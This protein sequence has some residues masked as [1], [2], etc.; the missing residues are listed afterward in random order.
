MPLI[1]ISGPAGEPVTSAEIKAS[2]RIDGAEFDSQIAIIIP[3]LRHQAEARIGRRL[4]TQTVELVLDEF[5]VADI[6]LTLPNVQSVISVKYLDVAGVEQTLASNLYSL[7]A[8]STPCWLLPAGDA[9]RRQ[10]RARALR[11]RVWRYRRQCAGRY[12]ALD[13]CPCLPSASAAGGHHF[14]HAGAAAVCRSL[15]GLSCRLA[16]DMRSGPSAGEFDQRVTLQTAAITR[17][18]VGGPVEAFSDWVTVWAAVKVVSGRRATLAQQ[19]GA[20]V[21]KEVHVRYR[22]GLSSALRVRFADGHVAK[23]S[24]VEDFLREGESV[25]VVEDLNG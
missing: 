3:A 5:P 24:W 12:P 15:A 16:V 25:L 17:D 14:R 13:D 22:S 6:D 4:I 11:G 7:D 21:T 8:S 10:R 1:D 2:A 18:A 9:G 19:V 23:V 20:A